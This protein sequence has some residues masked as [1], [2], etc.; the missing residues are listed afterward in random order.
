[1]RWFCIPSILKTGE[2][3]QGNLKS[4]SIHRVTF[5]YVKKGKVIVKES[6]LW[7]SY[8]GSQ[9]EASAEDPAEPPGQGFL[10][11]YRGDGHNG[12]VIGGTAL[13]DNTVRLKPY[14]N[15][16]VAAADSVIVRWN[17]DHLSEVM[18]QDKDI[19]SAVLHFTLNWSKVCDD[20]EKTKRQNRAIRKFWT[21]SK[22]MKQWLLKQ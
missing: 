22:S 5:E 21:K 10:Y 13:V 18:H 9:R 4:L 12:C 8:S 7:G 15:R 1:M 11:S 14:P 2:W 19:E 20:N 6:E 16:I 17:T 3:T